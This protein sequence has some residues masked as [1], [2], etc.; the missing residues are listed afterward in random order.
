M[1]FSLKEIL[2]AI[3]IIAIA[4]PFYR[5]ETSNKQLRA[6]NQTL[7]DKT[8][9]ITK[10]EGM[11][12]VIAIPSASSYTQSWRVLIPENSNHIF[13]LAFAQ[14][15]ISTGGVGRFPNL[16]NS[17]KFTA[18]LPKGISRLGEFVLSL[19]L[20]ENTP[21]IF[22][23]I[24][25]LTEHVF[26]FESKNADWVKNDEVY[27]RHPSVNVNGN[28]FTASVAPGEPLKLL[29]VRGKQASDGMVVFIESQPDHK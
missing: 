18:A 14:S 29:T 1:Q 8:A 23:R 7:R 6:E 4:I 21:R 26:E 16:D 17:E 28:G 15:N 10:A 25:G 13:R 22:W 12:S 9:S 2:L 11:L 3:V 5:S 20:D 24:H 27:N 19:E